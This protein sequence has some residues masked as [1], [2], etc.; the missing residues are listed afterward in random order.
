M[1]RCL[2]LMLVVGCSGPSEI[3]TDIPDSIAPDAV[4]CPNN[5]SDRVIGGE[6]RCGFDP[7]CADPTECRHGRCYVSDTSGDNCEFDDQCPSGYSCIRAHC[8]PTECEVEICDGYDNDC[9]GRLDEGSGSP[10]SLWCPSGPEPLPPCRRGVRVCI[11]GRFSA[12]MGGVQPVD[13]VGWFACDGIDNNCDGCVDGTLIDGVCEPLSTYIY[14]TVFVVDTSGSMSGSI[15]GLREELARFAEVYRG[16]M[17]F[18]FSLVTFPAYGSIS[19]GDVRSDFVSYDDF[20]PVISSLRANSGGAEPSYDVVADLLDGS[21]P[22]AWRSGAVRI[23]ILLTDE[24]GQSYSAPRN[25]EESM[26]AASTGGEVLAFI[27]P[28]THREDFDLCGQ[29]LDIYTSIH[30]SLH[31][32]IRNPCLP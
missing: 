27:T 21:L 24:E 28:T 4:V 9:D 10:L 23:I 32:L 16:R 3:D 30:G 20:E 18:R 2:I 6:C 5:T 31:T 11:D 1:S 29:W 13:E 22:L 14:D 12:C 26:C 17:E 15:L 7:P 25:T 19:G 8:S